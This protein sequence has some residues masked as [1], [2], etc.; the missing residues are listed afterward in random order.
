MTTAFQAILFDLDGVLIHSEKI[1]DQARHAVL[2]HYGISI[3]EAEQALYRGQTTKAVFEHI[4]RDFAEGRAS[5]AEMMELK[6]QFYYEQAEAKLAMI[7]GAL[8]FVR[9]LASTDVRLAVV[10]SASSQSQGFAF[11]R[12]GLAPYFSTVVTA[13]DVEHGKPA[14]E[15]YLLGAERLGTAPTRC[16]V[17]ED[18]VSGIQAAKAARCTA[19]GLT[20]S[21][22][23]PELLQAGADVAVAD[24]EALA[25]YV[26]GRA[27]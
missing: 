12:F 5:A 6:R 4:A 15:P 3:S 21:F 25:Q 26:A 19:A 9:H 11:E 16:L 7:P 13:D 10:T 2:D 27:S 24:F 8:D 20:T 14:P 22:S 17:I 23:A 1:H 18:S